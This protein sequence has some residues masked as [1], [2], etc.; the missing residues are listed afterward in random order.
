MSV[1]K[2]ST[3]E[4]AAP[5]G[6]VWV[7]VDSDTQTIAKAVAQIGETKYATLQDAVDAVAKNG[8]GHI[9]LIDDAPLE[10]ELVV[11]DGKSITLDLNGHSVN[12]GT[13]SICVKNGKL[14][15]EDTS[16]GD[17]KGSVVGTPNNYTFKGWINGTTEYAK[18]ATLPAVTGD[19]TYKA[20]YTTAASSHTVTFVTVGG[21]D[22]AAQTV[23]YGDKAEEP[24][25]PTKAGY[26]FDK[27]TLNG[28]D[29][30]FEA[31]VTGD[32]ILV[33]Q[34]SDAVAKIGDTYYPTLETAVNAA[35]DGDRVELLKN[36]SGNGIKV[37]ESKFTE[38]LTIDFGGHTYTM[39][40]TMVGSTGTETQA[41]QLLRNN[42]ITFQNG[43]I[44]SEKAKMLV[45]NYSDLTLDGMTLT[46]NNPNYASAYTLSNNNGSTTIKDTTINANPAG[47]FA[48]DVCRYSSYPSVSVTVKGDSVINGDV[49]V[50]A[51][52]NDPKDG[53]HLMLESGTLNG[54]I[55]LDSSAQ[56]VIDKNDHDK[57][58]VTELN[59]F[60]HE[61]ADGYGWKSNDD[62]TSSLARQFTV[63]FM[64]DGAISE[65]QPVFS[66]DTATE[67]EAD[68]TKAG[69]VFGGWFADGATA[70]F[71]FDTGI[72]EDITLTAKW[73]DAVAKIGDTY[74]THLADAVAAAKPGDTIQMVA[75]EDLAAQVV[76]DKSVTLDLNGKTLDN[77]Q[78]IWN[79]ADG[80]KAWSLISVQDGANVT[81]TGNGHLLA[82]KDDCY[83]ADVRDGSRLTIESG[84]FVGNISAVYVHDGE[85]NVKDGQF[86]VQQK[87][88]G[89][90]GYQFT[91]NC[92]DANY[93]N[94]TAKINVTGGEFYNFNPDDNA[95]EGANT[96][97]APDDKIGAEE[98]NKQHWFILKDAVIVT[99]EPDND[100]DE[101]WTEKIEKGARIE[102]P[103]IKKKTGHT[104]E[105]W[106]KDDGT[107]HSFDYS[108]IY[109]ATTLTAIWKANAHKV[110]YLSE[111]GDQNAYRTYENVAYGA[112]VPQPEENPSKE[113]YSFSGWTPAV[114]ATMGD[115]DLTFT[116]SWTKGAYKLTFYANADDTRAHATIAADFNDKVTGPADPAKVGYTFKGWAQ[117]ENATEAEELP[118]SMPAEDRTY[119]G[120][121]E[122]QQ[123]TIT[124]DTDGGSAIAAITQ[125]YNT[126]VAAPA[127]PTKTGY[128][129]IGWNKAVPD[130][131]PAENVTITGKWL[132]NSYTIVYRANGGAGA[133]DATTATYDAEVYLAANAF[134]REG[135][136]FNGWNTAADGSG[137]P[138]ADKATVKNLATIGNVSLFAQWTINTYKVKFVDEDGSTLK[139][140][141]NEETEYS[142]GTSAADIVQ[143][144]APTK[145]A[146]AQYTYIFDGWTPKLADVTADATYT[147]T[148]KATVIPY[149]VTFFDEDGTTVLQQTN[150]D[151]GERP[152]FNKAMPTKT[153]DAGQYTYTFKAWANTENDK[154]YAFG[155]E[156]PEVTGEVS[157][158]ATYT[159]TTNSYTVTWKDENG[160]ILGTTTV[161]YNANP[162][163]T[164]PE[165][166]NTDEY[167]YAFDKWVDEATNTGYAAADLPA[168][169]KDVTYRAKYIQTKR[170]YSISFVNDDG[171]VLTDAELVEYGAK[172]AYTGTPTSTKSEAGRIYTF[173]GWN[174]SVGNWYKPAELPVVTK[175]ATYKAHYVETLEKY[176]I[177]FVNDD[178]STQLDQKEFDYGTMPVYGGEAPAST[179]SESG[180][181]LT[182][183]G[184]EPELSAVTQAATYKARYT[185]TAAPY[186]ITWKIGD[187]TI[188]S[189]YDFGATITEP[190]TVAKVGYT[191]S[192]DPE[193]PATMP[194][195]D[196][197]ITAVWTPGKYT[198]SYTQTG[199]EAIAD[200]ADKDY[201]TA[202]TLPTP[203]RTGYTFRGWLDSVNN[204]TYPAGTQYT[205]PARN[206]ELSGQW[207]IN[208]FTVTFDSNGGSGVEAQQVDY[209]TEAH[210][211]AQ[212]TRSGYTFKAWQLDGTDYAFTNKVTADITLKATWT[213]NNVTVTFDTDGGTP[214]PTEQII[215]HS[216]LVMRPDDPIKT[217]ATFTG[218]YNGDE[219]YDFK[220]PVTANMTLKARWQ[221]DSYHVVFNTAGGSTAPAYQTVVYNGTASKPAD[222]TRDGYTFRAWQ[223][224]GTDYNFETPVTG[225]ITLVA[226]WIQTE[227]TVTFMV[228]GVQYAKQ[229]VDY[230]EMAI[231]PETPDKPGYTFKAWQLNSVNYSF[232]TPVTENLTLTA[233]FTANQ[234]TITWLN[235]DGT[236]IGMTQATGGETPTHAN[237]TKAA[238]A[239]YTYT[240]KGW[241]PEIVAVNGDATYVAQFNEALRSYT[242][243][244]TDDADKVIGTT[245][246]PYG[247]VPAHAYITKAVDA[248]YTYEFASW[249]PVLTK[250]TG[251]ATYKAKFN[252]TPR[253]YNITWVM[254]ETRVTSKYGFGEAIEVPASPTRTGYT[255]T[256]W[257]TR[258]PTAMPAENLTITAQ[259]KANEY[260]IRW[261][262]GDGKTLKTDKVAYGTRPAY[263]GTP[264]KAAT[265][266]YTYA[267]KGWLP[268]IANVTGDAT[269]TAQFTE[270]LRS[271]TITWQD[272]AGKTID[273]A[274]AAYGTM[275]T[276][277]NVAKA[278]DAQYT[279]TF[280]GW[281]PELTVVTG[282][283]T[284]KA[285]FTTT[286]KPYT[287]TWVMGAG[288]VRSKYGFGEAVEA[289]VNPTRTGY[290]FTGWDQAVPTTMPTRNLTITAQWKANEYSIRWV[291]GDGKT[292]KTDKVAYGAKPAYSGTPAKA[293]T[294]QY[295]YAFKG[296]L[297]E[298]ANVT[299]DAT[300][301]AQFTATTRKY[302]IT[303]QDDA[304]KTI[305]TATAD[306]GTMPAHADVAKAA[307][308]QYTYTFAGW[309]PEL[310]T[311]TG[312]AT[313]KARFTTTPKPY[314]ITWVM[315]ETRVIAKYRFG[316][317][318]EAPVNPTRTGYTFTGW[319]QAVPATM[320]AQNLTIT[321]QWKANEYSIKWV[322]GDGKTLKTDRMAYGAQPA[323]SG[324]PAKTATAQYT[325][326]F[327]GW[328]PEITNVTGDMTYTAQF[329]EK[330]RSYTITWQDDAGK[331][332]DTTT[333]A[334]G[335]VPTHADAAKA[336]DAQ[337]TYA[338]ARWTP[339]LTAV[340]GNATYKARFTSTPKVYAI[341]Y[342]VDKYKVV[343]KYGFGETVI[344]P[345]DPAKTGYTFTGWDPAIPATMPAND[346]T[347]T[348]Q[349]KIK[350]T[351]ITFDT[352]GGSKIDP[353]TQKYGTTLK[354]PAN[355]T[356]DGYIFTG[357]E[358]GLPTTM[359]AESMT[360]KATY[361]K[362][363]KIYTVKVT[364]KGYGTAN[365]SKT[366]GT[367]GTVVKLTQEPAKGYKFK[368]W[369][370][371]SGGVTVKDDSFTIGNADVEIRATF[372]Q[373]P[374]PADFTLLAKME[375]DGSDG[376]KFSW[377]EVKYADG[378]DIFWGKCD[379]TSSYKLV[380]SV[381]QADVRVYTVKKLGKNVSCKGYVKAWMMI[382]DTKVYIGEKSPTVHGYTSGGTKKVTNPKSVTLE[383][384]SKVALTV[385]MK[386]TIKATVTGLTAGKKILQHVA[387]LRYYTS[388]KKVATVTNK[389][390]INA[391][392]PGSCTIYVMAN[393]G[394][395]KSVKVTITAGPTSVSFKKKSYSVKVG[396]S[397]KLADQVELQP[398]GV[399]TTLTWATNNKKIATVSKKG[400]VK[401]VKKGKVTITV[402]TANGLQKT[403]KVTVK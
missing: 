141:G 111:A 362:D 59:T 386:S 185:E 172:P 389:G 351:T 251:D 244:W 9:M 298:I 329:T 300:Y 31:P 118:T 219:K 150:V 365:A 114:P 212:P 90:N 390:V 83:A 163:Y 400:V 357:W 326:A 33:A 120:V 269:Y 260:S 368:S 217:G 379:G 152:V 181:T 374:T 354:A 26:A 347:I 19:T 262:D 380:K 236:L 305:D 308:A 346:M 241:M 211:P 12:A 153:D 277:A 205:V 82:K 255:F 86:S 257:D 129:F 395:R 40:G 367:T 203:T 402:T 124:F 169:T 35:V 182:F 334:Y 55:V 321:A 96:S 69:S 190:G 234:Y 154:T 385:G 132:A 131:M 403:I 157:Y 121:W 175:N 319:D 146:D 148:Y 271:Y 249:D 38:G 176:Q 166:A 160:R 22:V 310:T 87:A 173:D 206:V 116:A 352:N 133:M 28:A 338:F 165:K 200:T 306:Y 296:W 62:G 52:G 295:T 151:Y 32:I 343:S 51:S 47:G 107:E 25:D 290:T 24:T 238:T 139:V 99:F 215:R 78:D 246:V 44:T 30:D 383:S 335:T 286:P 235:D 81:V 401:G 27:W 162:T 314:S 232:A 61:P 294:A 21:S 136:A 222:P 135:Y 168:V 283:A 149:A 137:M 188:V 93:R 101:A 174:D 331:T 106:Q 125:D 285:R 41:F 229:T 98:D 127:D 108:A 264:A 195:K 342:V 36:A 245:D 324:T 253:I 104:L 193:V 2:K 373:K 341:T 7:D 187:S 225:S 297:P 186:T 105:K 202:I 53:M 208:R 323:Y 79:D 5:D 230:G 237:A 393:N 179:R 392:A 198:V 340:T 299:G 227:R 184:W 263:S 80:V 233:V 266:Q 384:A 369:K 311:V 398:S 356:K 29:Y 339:E 330:L 332:I 394:V 126:A 112:E 376:L 71:D 320:P 348:A 360:V 358:P 95:A 39:D 254:G 276:H 76:I 302:T 270:K 370:V 64:V 268:E 23:A 117:S 67:P 240:F 316:T 74:F 258:V 84:E 265:A 143:P 361:K 312:N 359:P 37:P 191:F 252:K 231:A 243:T 1:R 89:G 378:Y 213:E 8:T 109:E 123:Y 122:I 221:A 13:N 189:N 15:I 199:D 54:D 130:T 336:A 65:T 128:T 161:E 353:I 350:K 228:D 10:K 363:T 210:E 45:Q 158:K 56:T 223:L 113:G 159:Q 309:S 16:T 267:F 197:T 284:Y 304:G 333:A 75:D 134:T 142:Y 327:K 6:Y 292:L 171:R 307:D 293:A 72:T 315:G 60:N 94:G 248:Q 399:A 147:A 177:T 103:A 278:A 375:S 371:V 4:H 273:T 201:N 396:K 387:I 167:A 291:D 66:G 11:G 14:D 250:V 63:T 92:Y 377:T 192:W 77:Q 259:W 100:I 194:A 337:Y 17:T 303:W 355:P 216:G 388:N 344:V 49:E 317:V 313:Y 42:N 226:T 275:P 287:I 301:T 156:L 115:E 372:A 288:S 247:E 397:L 328:L 220:T 48:F 224:N 43:T 57:A 345:T 272:D 50:S 102:Q 18:V 382:G 34:W 88:N 204:A 140:N 207:E 3:F 68:P 318:V 196:L 20:T 183:A 58:A 209:N 155:A 214:V 164:A 170:K 46:L 282:N 325:Y 70:A 119:Y 145:A 110:I 242:I 274:T 280:A 239:Q 261:V 73:L 91:L 178:R 289:P 218:W 85:L 381:K 256:G 138:Y 349:W 364:I 322:D 281:T 279:Y 144:E 366:K 97:F 391:V 180:K